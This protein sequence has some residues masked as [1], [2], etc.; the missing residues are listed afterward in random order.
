MASGDGDEITREKIV[1]LMIGNSVSLL[2]EKG[3]WNDSLDYTENIQQA[4]L[5]IPTLWNEVYVPEDI[6]PQHLLGLEVLKRIG[7]I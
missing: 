4:T 3:L 1:K 6:D 2:K 7:G 5:K